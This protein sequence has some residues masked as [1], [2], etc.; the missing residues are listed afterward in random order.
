ML[1][2]E[3]MLGIVLA[4][5]VLNNLEQLM[6][7]ALFAIVAIVGIALLGFL[8]ESA[9]KVAGFILA[10]LLMISFVYVV[11]FVGLLFENFPIVRSIKPYDRRKLEDVDEENMFVKYSS[12]LFD[13]FT[14]GISIFACLSVLFLISWLSFS[15]DYAEFILPTLFVVILG[16]MKLFDKVKVEGV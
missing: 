11:C 15:F 14:I 3:I 8:Y 12:F 5:I 1:I 4:V 7:I 2:L 10:L 6:T 16:V 13:R 9:G